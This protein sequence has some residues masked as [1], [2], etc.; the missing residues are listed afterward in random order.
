VGNGIDSFLVTGLIGAMPDLA[1]FIGNE[2][3]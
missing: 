1:K 3:V 2:F